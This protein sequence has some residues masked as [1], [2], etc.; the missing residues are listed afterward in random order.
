[1]YTLFIS[2]SDRA[3]E[4]ELGRE[5]EKMTIKERSEYLNQLIREINLRIGDWIEAKEK[6]QKMQEFDTE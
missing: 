4:D 5:V 3:L 2:Y 1:M 6:L